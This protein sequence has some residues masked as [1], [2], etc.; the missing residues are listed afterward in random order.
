MADLKNS[1]SILIALICVVYISLFFSIQ[2]NNFAL[3]V[4]LAFCLLSNGVR[5]IPVAVKDN[6]VI[7]LFLVLYLVQLVGLTYSSNLHAGYFILEKKSAFLLVPLILLPAIQKENIDRDRLLKYT[8]II[9]VASSLALIAVALFKKFVLDDNKAFFYEEFTLI[10]YVYYAMYFACGSLLLIDALFDA[11]STNK[12]SRVLIVIVFIYALAI[13][14]LVASKTGIGAFCI[15]AMFLLYQRIANKK[16]FVA[17][18]L[19]FAAATAALLYFNSTTWNRFTEMNQSLSF[20]LLDDLRG[21]EVYITDLTMRLVFW[22][23]SM[24][25]LWHDGFFVT[26]VG[27]G[28]AQDYINSL[29]VKPQYGLYSYVNWDSH[30]Q[31]VFT[32]VQL[33]LLGVLPMAYLYGRYIWQALRKTDTKFLSFLL[34][35]GAFSLS[36]SILESN[37]GIVFFAILFTICCVTYRHEKAPA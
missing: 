5:R 12:H 31:W 18:L 13:L 6:T 23:I 4:L 20:L 27:T 33:G 25:N 2:V 10:H 32:L 30:N 11:V 28:D 1:K 9:T 16:I 14:V 36:E 29:Y 21:A 34:V 22:K 24:V 8:G 37:K 35:T 3:G 15:G 19:I 7:R 17:A 26:G